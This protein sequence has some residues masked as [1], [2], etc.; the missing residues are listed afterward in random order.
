[1]GNGKRKLN[2]PSSGENPFK[3][4]TIEEGVSLGN[5]AHD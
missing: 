2:I 5:I 1:M 4:V 3:I